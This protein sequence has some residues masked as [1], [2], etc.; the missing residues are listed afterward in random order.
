MRPFT[1]SAL[2]IFLTLTGC[3]TTRPLPPVAKPA[4]PDPVIVKIITIPSGGIISWNG[5]TLGTGPIELKVTPSHNGCWPITGNFHE[6]FEARWLDGSHAIEFY[7]TNSRIP[8]C[9][10]LADRSRPLAQRTPFDPSTAVPV[11]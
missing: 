6:Q 2:I 3:A 9:I 1:K 8:G 5:D 11:D 7:R 10:L 4:P